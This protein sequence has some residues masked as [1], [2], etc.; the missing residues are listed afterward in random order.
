MIMCS[1]TVREGFKIYSLYNRDYLLD[2][3]QTSPMQGISESIK[4]PRLTDIGNM[5]YN[6]YKQLLYRDRYIVYIDNFFISVDLFNALKDIS[7]SVVNIIKTGSFPAELL[8]LNRL[9]KK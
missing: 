2:F 3:I 4:I 5:V 6:L 9:L 8:T 1:K 7:I